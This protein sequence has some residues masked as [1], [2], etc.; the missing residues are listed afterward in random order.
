[1][2]KALLVLIVVFA[3]SCTQGPAMR[4]RIRGLTT[5]V[6]DAE[7][8]GAMRCAPRVSWRSG[9]MICRARRMPRISATAVAPT[10]ARMID[11]FTCARK[12]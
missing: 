10:A 7:K 1:M 4:G 2:S 11:W 9:R 8:N 5:T 12:S 3:C 6:T